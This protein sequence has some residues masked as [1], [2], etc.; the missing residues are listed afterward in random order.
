MKKKLLVLIPTFF[1]TLTACGGDEPTPPI[2]PADQA[3]N[4]AKNLSYDEHFADNLSVKV[5]SAACI[6]AIEAAANNNTNN[7]KKA[8]AYYNGNSFIEDGVISCEYK[9]QDYDLYDEYAAVIRQVNIEE[10]H[11]LATGVVN[12]TKR[13]GWGEHYHDE[14]H[15]CVY[16]HEVYGGSHN[17]NS[18]SLEGHDENWVRNIIR[19]DHTEIIEGCFDNT[20]TCE[21]YKSGNKYIGY[22]SNT[23]ELDDESYQRKTTEQIIYEF[24]EDFHLIYGS[25][26]YD[27]SSNY[28]HYRKVPLTE[29]KTDYSVH[30]IYRGTYGTRKAKSVIYS[31]IE[32]LYG[33]PFFDNYIYMVFD[34]A[35]Y[36]HK[37]IFITP[38]YVKIEAFATFDEYSKDPIDI[39]PYIELTIVDSMLADKGHN[40][41]VNGKPTI[42]SSDYMA[43]VGDRL[44]YTMKN[45]ND[46]AYFVLEYELVDGLPE[47]RGGT[48]EHANKDEM[49]EYFG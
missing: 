33:K 5:D 16:E 31:N 14:A 17:L 49:I 12:A 24:D 20:E 38:Q 18:T 9:Y 1:L 28:D 39:T 42:K 47:F 21:F 22:Y 23:E 27:D 36:D 45:V 35:N 32:A 25:Y 46:A 34:N 6:S 8:R 40:H 19:W 43:Y 2:S 4:E 15:Q 3:I 41:E 13:E 11:Y 37:E 48:V 26:Y 29:M 30:E 10:D 44:F 7:L